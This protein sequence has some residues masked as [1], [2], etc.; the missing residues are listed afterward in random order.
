MGKSVVLRKAL[1]HLRR[2]GMCELDAWLAPLESVLTEQPQLADDV[3]A[4]LTQEPNRLLAM[5]EG[6]L[7]IPVALRPWLS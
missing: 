1:F 5:M 4:L 6:K 3:E 7:P 2:Q